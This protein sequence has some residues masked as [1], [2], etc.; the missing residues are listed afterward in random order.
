MQGS[1]VSE[2]VRTF[3]DGYAEAFDDI[4]ERDF[5]GSTFSL[6]HL[7]RQSMWTRFEH[8]FA[9]CRPLNGASFLDLGCG[10]GQYSIFAAQSGAG[11][12]TGLDLSEEMIALAKERASQKGV[13]ARCDFRLG[14]VVKSEGIEP[15]DF[16]VAL[17]VFDYIETPEE[18]LQ[19]MAALTKVRLVASFPK[20]N[21]PLTLQ[22][23][24][25]YQMRGCPLYFYTKGDLE[26][27]GGRLGAWAIHVFDLGRD[28]LFTAAAP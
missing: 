2:D 24:I 14:D 17:G 27:M 20:R 18:L 19:R 15:H 3:F 10:S 11:E 7:L 12:V 4:Y 22:R 28:Y 23:K 25:R 26:A 8:T 16:T 21:H 9:L 5:K 1:G 6:S 13:E